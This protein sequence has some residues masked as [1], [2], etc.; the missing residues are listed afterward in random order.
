MGMRRLD[1]SVAWL[2]CSLGKCRQTG[3][4]KWEGVMVEKG[5]MVNGRKV[6]MA[7]RRRSERARAA[8]SASGY[9]LA[10]DVASIHYLRDADAGS[11]RASL[12]KKK[13][14]KK[15]LDVVLAHEP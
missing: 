1:E 14:K 4:E 11:W 6:R 10:M 9:Q 5:G 13:N 15:E 2:V 7:T 8:T 3:R 12:A